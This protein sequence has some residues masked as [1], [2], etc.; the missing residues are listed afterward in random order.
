M[1]P[2]ESF[3]IVCG[4]TLKLFI[5]TKYL[6]SAFFSCPAKK[7]CHCYGLYSFSFIFSFYLTTVMGMGKN[8]DSPFFIAIEVVDDKLT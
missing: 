4:I 6:V 5:Y 7:I 2:K 8:G 1:I 3:L